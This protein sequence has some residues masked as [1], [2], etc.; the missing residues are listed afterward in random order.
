M[1]NCG[2]V[3]GSPEKKKERKRHSSTHTRKLARA[4]RR[5]PLRCRTDAIRSTRSTRADVRGSEADFPAAAVASPIR[6]PDCRCAE[7]SADTRKLFSNYAAASAAAFSRRATPRSG[8]SV[9]RQVRVE[10]EAA[11]ET[12]KKRKRA[13]TD[14]RSPSALTHTQKRTHPSTKPKRRRRRGRQRPL[15]A[16]VADCRHETNP[17]VSRGTAA[18]S[19][20]AAAGLG[21]KRVCFCE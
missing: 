11:K 2:A 7:S 10:R 21:R 20:E 16:E 3:R 1:T 6:R 12:N 5:A 4:E 14:A 19:P 9:C 18:F 13:N 15:L 8:A 17:S